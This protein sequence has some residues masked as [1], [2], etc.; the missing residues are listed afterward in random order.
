[1]AQS[2]G[3]QPALPEP[4]LGQKVSILYRLVGDE[5]PFTEVVGIVQR[6]AD[7]DEGEPTIAVIRRNADLVCVRRADIV[8]MKIVPTHG[9]GPF[10]PPRSWSAAQP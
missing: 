10:K 2:S 4:K 6:I 1:M 8:R 7:N 5:Y 3:S 9:K